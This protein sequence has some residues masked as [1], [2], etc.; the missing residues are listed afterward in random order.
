MGEET[1]SLPTKYCQTGKIGNPSLRSKWNSYALAFA[2][3]F[4]LVQ[5]L[6]VALTTIDSADGAQDVPPPWLPYIYIA[7]P[8]T[9]TTTTIFFFFCIFLLFI[10]ILLFTTWIIIIVVFFIY[11]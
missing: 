6:A 11:Y 4:V 3:V 1:I 5:G 9:T 2:F 8:S 7:A 10:I